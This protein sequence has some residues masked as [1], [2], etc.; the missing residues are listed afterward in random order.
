[1]SNSTIA[2]QIHEPL[3]IHRDFAAQIALNG[4]LCNLTAQLLELFFAQLAD[5]AIGGH[6]GIGADLVRSETPIP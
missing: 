4:V 1:M 6:T 2:T 3:D 5:F